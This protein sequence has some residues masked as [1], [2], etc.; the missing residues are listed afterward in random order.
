MRAR[1]H[2]DRKEAAMGSRRS[3]STRACRAAALALALAPGCGVKDP[4]SPN[5]FGEAG[6]DGEGDD[7]DTGGETSTDDTFDDDGGPSTLPTTADDDGADSTGSDPSTDTGTT[8]TDGGEETIGL[9][10]TS[11]AGAETAIED[12]GTDTF[13]DG[14]VDVQVVISEMWERGECD[15]VTVTNISDDDVIW[16][17]ELELPGTI[18]NLWNANIVEADGVGTFTGVDFNASIAPGASAMFGFCV[19]Y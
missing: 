19:N 17:I 4:G 7:D 1:P 6:E 13:S 18:Y 9:D 8:G 10:D 11:T 16:E 3:D 14:T 2:A 5:H 12:S 15:D